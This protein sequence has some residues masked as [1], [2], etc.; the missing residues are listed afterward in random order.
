MSRRHKWLPAHSSRWLVHFRPSSVEHPEVQVLP[1]SSN[2]KGT[3]ASRLVPP[4]PSARELDGLEGDAPPCVHAAPIAAKNS[5]KIDRRTR[6][7]IVIPPKVAH[8]FLESPKLEEALR[9]AV[10]FLRPHRPHPAILA[11]HSAS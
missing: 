9:R 7:A 1:R 4:P 3:P 5:E 2:P 8:F 6:R 11:P 10:P